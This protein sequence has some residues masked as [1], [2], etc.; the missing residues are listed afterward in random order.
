[1]YFCKQIPVMREFA[2]LR[3][4]CR[5]PTR[6]AAGADGWAVFG[7]LR[8]PARAYAAC[9]DTGG[10]PA[11][12]SDPILVI[13]LGALGNVVLSLGPMAAIRRHHP[14]AAITLLTTDPYAQWLA[15][16]PWFDRIWTGGRPGWWDVPALLR[17]RRLLRGGGFRRVYDLQTSH[18]SSR[19]LSLFARN[20][21]PEWSGIAPGCSHP[22]TQPDRARL[23]DIDRQV[24]QL[25]LAGIETVPPPDLSWT[26]ADLSRFGLPERFALLVPGSSAH[27]PGKRWPAAAYGRLAHAL[28]ARGIAPV[29][30][31]APAERPLAAEIVRASGAVDLTGQTGLAELA[32]LGRA[33]AVAVGNDTGP[34]HLLAAAGC[35]S[36]VLFSRESDPALCAPRGGEVTVLRRPD[37]ADLEETA[38][39]AA[40]LAR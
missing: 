24:G 9:T 33:A 17:L 36:V 30:L 21:R 3:L 31:G 39:L 7:R 29:V 38:V 12:A 35:R 32:A 19:Y 16:A 25:R 11:I 2:A 26:R 37:L 8:A 18:R 23:H 20:A 14:E 22:D 5:V 40:A 6:Y 27:R 28:A 4:P 1:L 10:P 34:M 13:K 15:A